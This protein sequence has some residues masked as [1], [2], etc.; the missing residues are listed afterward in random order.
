MHAICSRSRYFSSMC[1]DDNDDE[2]TT[3]LLMMLMIMLMLMIMMMMMMMMGTILPIESEHIIARGFLIG[4][5]P[6][7]NGVSVKLFRG[8][9]HYVITLLQQYETLPAALFTPVSSKGTCI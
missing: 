8:Y 3:M 6:R 5:R 7:L 1:L 9:A 2:L 4:L